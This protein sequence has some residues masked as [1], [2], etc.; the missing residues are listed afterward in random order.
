MSYVSAYNCNYPLLFV[1]C[2]VLPEFA[3]AWFKLVEKTCTKGA[4]V[5]WA[6]CGMRSL[7]PP[8]HVKI[9]LRKSES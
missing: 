8:P 6:F 3:H 1:G 4:E 2:K 7:R 9:Q 5:E